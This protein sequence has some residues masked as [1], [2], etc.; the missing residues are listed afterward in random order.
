MAEKIVV[1]FIIA[2]TGSIASA[3]GSALVRYGD[4]V[5]ICGI[6]LVKKNFHHIIFFYILYYSNG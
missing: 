2:V 6:K 4:T 1:S 5:V 3:D